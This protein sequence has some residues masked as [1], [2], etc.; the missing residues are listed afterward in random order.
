MIR[1]ISAR[2]AASAALLALNVATASPDT[3]RAPSRP[4]VDTYHGVAITDPYRNL[5]NLRDTPSPP[6]MKA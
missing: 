1:S 5:E 6:H 2:M 4:V 3:V